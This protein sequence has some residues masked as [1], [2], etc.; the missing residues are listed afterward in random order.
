MSQG[1]PGGF[2][3]SFVQA[4]GT[5]GGRRD[6]NLDFPLKIRYNNPMLISVEIPDSIARSLRLDGPE[7]DRR[8][9]EML[10]L[11]GYKSGELSAGQVGQMLGMGFYETEGFLKRNNACLHYSVEDLDQDRAALRHFLA[12]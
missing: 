10:A 7:P 6:A 12:R 11:E 8:A 4:V 1:L 5:N 2:M 3:L 9:L